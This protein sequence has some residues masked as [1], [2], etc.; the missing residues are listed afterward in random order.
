M[1]FPVEWTTIAPFTGHYSVWLHSVNESG[2]YRARMVADC[3]SLAAAMAARRLL[4]EG[5]E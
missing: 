4:R 1:K 3:P 2:A 5:D